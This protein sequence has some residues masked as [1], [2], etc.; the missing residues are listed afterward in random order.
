MIGGTVGVRRRCRLR[1]VAKLGVVAQ[2]RVVVKVVE[3]V[4]EG[5]EEVEEL[6]DGVGVEIVWQ[7]LR[8]QRTGRASHEGGGGAGIR[9]ATRRGRVAGGRG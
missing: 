4:G 7:A 6:S 1:R 2:Q 5:V 8:A 9:D 3:V